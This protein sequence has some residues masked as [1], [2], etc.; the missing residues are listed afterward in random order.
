[1][2]ND[3]FMI[4]QGK[5]HA[6]SH[7]WCDHVPSSRRVKRF[8]ASVVLAA[9]VVSVVHSGSLAAGE[10][11]SAT[12]EVKQTIDRVLEILGDEKLKKP[13]YADD[14]I[15]AIEDVIAQRFDYEEMAKRTL[16]REWKKLSPEQQKEFVSLFQRFL[17]K[18]YAGNVDGYSGE[19]V[20]YIKER[21]KGD[22]AEVQTKVISKKLEVPLDYRLL[23][24]SSTWR[25]YDV[26]IDGVSLVK[27][28][29]GQFKRIIKASGFSGLVD[30]LRSKIAKT[31]AQ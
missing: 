14:R 29:R 19:Q 17:S 13:E 24:N 25:V 26:V 20:E 18:T 27:N 6:M 30:K 31:S 28:F 1:L 16:G 3:L 2:P 4:F 11:G 12:K 10:S 7:V 15:A 8:G 5:E 9:F 21:R 22:F 23:K